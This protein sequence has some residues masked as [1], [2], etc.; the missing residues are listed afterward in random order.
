MKRILNGCRV[1][2]R[3]TRLIIALAVLAS[4]SA[5]V[6]GPPASFRRNTTGLQLQWP[7]APETAKVVWVKEVKN[8]ADVGI[9]KTFWK[10]VA[11]FFSGAEDMRIERPYGILADEKE[12]LFIVDVGRGVVHFLNIPDKTEEVI[13]EGKELTVPIGI[14]EDDGDSIYITDSAARTV[15][16]YN[17]RDKTLRPFTPFKFGRPTGIAFNRTNRLI[18]VTDT[19]MHQIRAF[20]LDGNE[21]YHFGSRGEGAGQFNFPTDLFIDTRG[22]LYVTD[23][24]NYRIQIFSPDGKFLKMFGEAGDSAGNLARPKGVAVDSEGHIYICDALSDTV[25]VFDDAG[26]LL[27]KLGSN[28]TEP[29]LF[30]MP[31]GMY[32]DGNDYIYVADTYNH[33]IQVLRYVK[34]EDSGPAA[35]E[36]KAGTGATR[37]NDPPVVKR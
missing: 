20:S 1:T 25:Q 15:F 14:T 29:G 13:G 18:Y 12:R 34:E 21:R 5:C 31:S 16:R 32:I 28:G 37:G 17:L 6:T 2:C 10:R 8:Y 33:R 7:P 27:L 9:P 4:T 30:W 36:K 23:S 26:K 22:N 3:S 11:E 35:D 24:L 19:A